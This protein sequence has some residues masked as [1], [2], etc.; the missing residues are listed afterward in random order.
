M[1][2]ALFVI[3]EIAAQGTIKSLRRPGIEPG[4][5]AWKAAM[6][7]IIP[8][9]QDLLKSCPSTDPTPSRELPICGLKGG[10]GRALRVHQPARVTLVGQGRAL[11]GFGR[12]A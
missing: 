9:T 3:Y 12:V 8:P 2:V 5:T 6:L 10:H 7:T 4:S 1:L 11:E